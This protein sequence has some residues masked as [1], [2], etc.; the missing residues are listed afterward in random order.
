MPDLFFILRLY[1]PHIHLPEIRQKV[2]MSSKVTFS[3]DLPNKARYISVGSSLTLSNTDFEYISISAN[4]CVLL[5][6]FASHC[7]T[8]CK[9]FSSDIESHRVHDRSSMDLS[10]YSYLSALRLLALQMILVMVSLIEMY[11]K[12]LSDNSHQLAYIGTL[13]MLLSNL[14]S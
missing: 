3:T 4:I 7:M 2:H 6:S 1:I 8:I 10:L 9:I 13:D 14:V 5:S 11:S 12:S